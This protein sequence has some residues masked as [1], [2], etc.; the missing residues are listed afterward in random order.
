MNS[1]GGGRRAWT[2]PPAVLYGTLTLLALLVAWTLATSV[3]GLAGPRVLPA[4]VDVLMRAASLIATPFS[5]ATLAGH[6]LA[7]LHRWV[8]GVACAIALG[9]PVGVLLAWLPPVRAAVAPLF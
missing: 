3:L 5:G 4:P 1:R 9:I 7:S 8:I 6:A 2:V